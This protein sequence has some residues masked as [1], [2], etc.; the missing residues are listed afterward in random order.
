MRT[1]GPKHFLFL[2]VVSAVSFTFPCTL[3]SQDI[4]FSQYYQAPMYLNPAFAGSA[5]HHRVILHN[6][7][8]WPSLDA[9]YTTI[10]AS[11][12][13]YYNHY[14]SGFGLMLTSDH[15][16]AS[17]ISS[18]DVQ[19]IYSY[20][21]HL[22]EDYTFRFGLQ[23]GYIRRNID[24]SDRTFPNQFS[25]DGYNAALGNGE[26][27][28][29]MSKNMLD[30]SAGGIFYSHQAW[31]GIA[32]H[33][34]NTPNQSYIGQ[35]SPYPAKFSVMGGYKILLNT[36]H[37]AFFEDVKEISLTPTFLY[38]SQGK[39]DQLDMGIY[40]T[41]DQLIIG[42]WYR[43]IPFKTYSNNLSNSE[44][45]IA[46]FGWHFE[47]FSV[48]YSYDYVVSSLKQARPG[49]AHELNLTYIFFKN[50]RGAKPMKKLPCPT[51]YKHF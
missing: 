15:Q 8:Q 36:A 11:Y 26:G 38:K 47:H 13:T 12:D 48:G 32:A 17:G 51:F 28:L 10:Q 21:L 49:G 33:H 29:N 34:L 16:G 41:Y 4:Q 44:S 19:A 23:G 24:I 5:H 1:K 42:A 35:T 46:F 7:L 18:T 40:L 43:G 3:Y 9:K 45:A 39:S 2:L 25:S 6:R 50:H 14:R 30:I 27:M 37:H 22:H 20:E 31:V